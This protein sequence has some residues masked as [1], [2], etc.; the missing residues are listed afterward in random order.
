M[1]G[2]AFGFQKD[3][4]ID[5]VPRRERFERDHPEWSIWWEA[6]RWRWHAKN[7]KTDEELHDYPELRYLL[8]DLE[9][10][11]TA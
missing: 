4:P 6:D 3:E 11:A 1:S 2:P 9:K 7:P 10:R 8:D 5:Q